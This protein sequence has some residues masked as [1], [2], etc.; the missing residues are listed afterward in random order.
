MQSKIERV[1]DVFAVALVE[2][3]VGVGHSFYGI[4]DEVGDTYRFV[5]L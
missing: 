1:D 4:A 2:A 3:G 5:L